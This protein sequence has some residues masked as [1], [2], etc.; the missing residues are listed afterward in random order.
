VLAFN[1]QASLSNEYTANTDPTTKVTYS[2]ICGRVMEPFSAP[3]T[4]LCLI[5][6][7][8]FV[9][10]KQACKLAVVNVSDV[11]GDSD[12]VYS[13][14]SIEKDFYKPSESGLEKVIKT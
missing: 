3:V 7:I 8:S 12:S 5:G 10:E 6:R 1:T 9:F 11:N 4:H 13:D 2:A 14:V